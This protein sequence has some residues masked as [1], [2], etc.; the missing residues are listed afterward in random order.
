MSKRKGLIATKYFISIEACVCEESVCQIRTTN[1]VRLFNHVAL[2][3][4]IFSC[5]F[6][7]DFFP[8][9]R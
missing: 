9:G 7:V 4:S 3:V 5:I 6:V 2:T 1:A 8:T